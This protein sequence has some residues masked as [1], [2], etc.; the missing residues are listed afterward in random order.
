FVA[1]VFFNIGQGRGKN[2]AQ[3]EMLLFKDM[4]RLKRLSFFRNQFME[5]ALDS[6]AEVSGGCS[7]ITNRQTFDLL[8]DFLVSDVFAIV[9]E[10]RAGKK[11]NTTYLVEPLRSSTAVEKFSGTIGGSDNST[12]KISSTMTALTHYILQS[13]ACRLAFTDLQG[14]LHS[15]RPGAPRELVLFDPMTHSLSRQ[16]G[17]G[18]HG[19]EGIDDTIST[20]RCSFMCKAMKLANM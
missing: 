2:L 12:N 14:S 13:T 8:R 16:T 3:N 10:S 11:V 5:A 6:G 17:V 4:V 1:K 7:F 15:G 9:V 18:D 19:P 20:H